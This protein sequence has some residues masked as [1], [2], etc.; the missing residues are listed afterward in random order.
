MVGTQLKQQTVRTSHLAHGRSFLDIW[1]ASGSQK[2]SQTPHLV[3]QA[4]L[5]ELA[6]L[7]LFHINN[8]YQTSPPAHAQA[9]PKYIFHP[10]PRAIEIAIERARP[11][12]RATAVRFKLPKFTILAKVYRT[13]KKV[14]PHA[15]LTLQVL[16]F[17]LLF[18]AFL[19]F[20]ELFS[21]RV[22]LIFRGVASFGV[23]RLIGGLL[24]DLNH[25]QNRTKKTNQNTTGRSSPNFAF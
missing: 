14:P 19:K 3:P 25:S 1:C 7:H 9:H 18:T 12:A 10:P 22:A 15:G 4:S 24:K 6:P 11:N 23:T 20:F 2:M 17:C 16:F 8:I 5:I 21:T 13:V